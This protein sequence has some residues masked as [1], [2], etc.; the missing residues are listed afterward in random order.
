MVAQHHCLAQ[1]V[2]A[3]PDARPK[4][5]R[6]RGRHHALRFPH[7]QRIVHLLAHARER[8]ADRRLAQGQSVGGARQI[9]LAVNRRKDA[10]KV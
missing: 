4:S 5:M 8:M 7:E 1:H 2:E 6:K 9:A 10:K 3:I